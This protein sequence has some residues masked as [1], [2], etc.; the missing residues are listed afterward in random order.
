MTVQSDKALAAPQ[1]MT[2][3]SDKALAAPQYMTVQ[4]DKALAAP[5]YIS[6]QSTNVLEGPQYVTV[7]P[8]MILIDIAFVMQYLKRECA[9]VDATKEC[10]NSLTMP[11]S[12]NDV[13]FYTLIL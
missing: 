6:V 4:S 10:L 5:Q 11:I 12:L 3:Q 1:C 8:D 13:S 9:F 7:H 2:V